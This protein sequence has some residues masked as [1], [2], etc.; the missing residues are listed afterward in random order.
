MKITLKSILY[1]NKQVRLQQAK[2]VR[3]SKGFDALSNHINRNNMINSFFAAFVMGGFLALLLF[4]GHWFVSDL[5]E[6]DND[7]D[8]PDK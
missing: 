6:N 7:Q 3:Q 4:V 2:S 8:N 5:F 1:Y